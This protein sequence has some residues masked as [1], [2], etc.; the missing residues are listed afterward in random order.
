MRGAGQNFGIVIET[1]YKIFK[2]TNGGKALNVDLILPASAN[3]THWE[4][5]KKIAT[6][7]PA[8]LS[9]FTGIQYNDAY[10]GINILFN[11]V[12]YGPEDKGRK[13]LAPII[14]NN[15]LV[16]NI[17]YI[18]AIDV[19]PTSLFGRFN[20][21]MCKKGNPVSTYTVGIKGIDIPTLNT[22]FND[23]NAFWKQYPQTRASTIYYETLPIQAVKK[24]PADFNSY[25][26]SHREIETHVLM[27]YVNN[28]RS[29][30][31][32]VEQLANKNRENLVKTSG[33][34]QLELY[35]TYAHGDEGVNA[36]YR[37]SLPRLQSLKTKY[38]PDNRF[39]FFNPIRG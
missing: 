8:E 19:I 13:L 17:S 15:P 34:N 9:M 10:G 12:Y 28:D 27:T 30:D 14:A 37:D 35:T 2:A 31:G 6:N 22:L 20:D 39:R 33:F 16:T 3:K 23:M 38:D 29:I 25:P 32:A 21:P 11:A 4:L 5:L 1:T 36:W 18:N 24:V 26:P 7:V